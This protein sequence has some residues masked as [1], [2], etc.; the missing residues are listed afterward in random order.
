MTKQTK[1]TPKVS[2]KN[3]NLYGLLDLAVALSELATVYV[4]ATQDNQVLWVLA[5]VL[6]ADCA[7]RFAR[8]FV[9]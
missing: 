6:G 5:A 8:K 4:F 2:K 9:K 1:D 3:I 7:Q